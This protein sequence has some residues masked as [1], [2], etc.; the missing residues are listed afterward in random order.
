MKEQ[1][2][3]VDEPVAEVKEEKT[4]KVDENPLG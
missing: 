4:N 1:I 2:A 3:K